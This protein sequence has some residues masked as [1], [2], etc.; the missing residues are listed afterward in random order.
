[1][2]TTPIEVAESYL[3]SFSKGNADFISEHVD[4]N[5]ENIHT[6]ALGEPCFGRDVYRENLNG[7]LG[8]FEGISYEPIE[9]VSE[10][11][12]VPSKSSK[13][14]QIDFMS[15]IMRAKVDGTPIEIEGVFQFLIS[16]GLIKRRIDYFDS[17]T[18]LKQIGHSIG[19]EEN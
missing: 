3:N 5:F 7:F 4:Q 19:S 6:S 1:M 14:S 16:D 13:K 2:G 12:K 11:E 17:L 10:N 9:A 15:Y 8:K 18:F